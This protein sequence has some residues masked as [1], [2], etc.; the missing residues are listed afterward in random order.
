MVGCDVG[1][2]CLEGE[3]ILLFPGRTYIGTV[4]GLKTGEL[5]LGDRFV[6]WEIAGF[7]ITGSALARGGTDLIKF[8]GYSTGWLIGAK[9]CEFWIVVR[10]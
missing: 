1:T 6:F 7:R 3:A 9:G 10:F 4:S 2:N 8:A 5:S